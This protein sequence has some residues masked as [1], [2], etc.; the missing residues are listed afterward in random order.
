MTKFE[1]LTLHDL[2]KC[3]TH[4]VESYPDDIKASFVDEI[5][6]LK[7][8][9]MF[10]CIRLPFISHTCKI[11]EDALGFVDVKLVFELKY[12]GSV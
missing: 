7:A 1:S 6:Q 10:K 8:I 11:I 12:I 2:R 5:V 9:S 3:A 4:L